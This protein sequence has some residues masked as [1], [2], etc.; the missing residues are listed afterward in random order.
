MY[1]KCGSI[2]RL[3]FVVGIVLA[4]VAQSADPSLVAWYRFDGDASDS[5]G[6]GLHGSEVGDPTYVEGVFGQALDL[7]G[8]GDYID[9]GNPPEFDIREVITFMYWIHVRSFDADWNTVIAKGDNSWRSSRAG[10]NNY[11]E[12]AVS[13]TSGNYLYSTTPVDDGQWHHIAAVYDGATFSIYV[14]GEPDGSEASTGQIASSTYSV[15][16][17]E[18]SQATGRHW[19]GLIDDLMIFNSVLT[20]EEIR[21]IMQSSAG[22]YPFSS[23]PSP[24]DGAL[25][26]QTWVTMSWRA[27]DLA[28]SHDVYFSDNFDDVNSGA[29]AAFHGNKAVT[30]TTLIAGFAGFP[31]PEGLVPGT[32]Y[33]WRVDEVNDSEPNSPWIGNVW[34]FWVPP[35]QAYEPVPAD[36]TTFVP[37]DV[38]LEWTPGFNAKLHYVYFGDDPDVVANATGGSAVSTTSFD[39]G[40]LEFNKTY[41]WRVDEFDPP[42]THRGE[43]WSFATTLPGLGTAV[44]GRWENLT[45]TDLNTLKASPKYP[46]EP[47]VTETVDSFLWD[48]ADL[49]DYGARIEAWVYAPATGDYTFWLNTDDQGEL[50]LSTN[51]DP[52]NARLIAQESSWAPFG[53]WGTGEEQS[54]P[55]PLVGGEKYYI[56]AIWKEGGGGDHCQVGWQGPG[57]PERTVIPG[58]NLSPFEPVKAYGANPANMAADVKQTPTLKWK[59]GIH[60]ES[61]EV[62]FGSDEAAV[63]N[64]TKAS[65]E[66][67][68]SKALG[69]ESFETGKLPWDSSFYWRIDEVADGNP[70]SPWVGDVWSFTTADFVI[71][72]NFEDYTDNDAEGEAVWQTWLDGFGVD[73][74]GSQ[75]GNAVPP[76][77]E[78]NTVQQGRQSVELYYNNVGGVTNSEVERPLEDVRDWTEGGVEEF[79]LWFHGQPASDGSFVE[80]PVGTFTMTG[81]GADITGN[82][83]EFHYAYEMLTGAGSIVARVD[84]VEETHAW[85]KAGVMIRNTLDAGS[86]HAMAFVTPGNGVVFEY[87]PDTDGANV[88]AAGQETGITAPH[89]VKIERDIGGNFTA[90]HS[91]DGSAWQPLGAP[92]N[93]QMGGT[94]F[95]GL[96]LT[97]HDAAATTE[98]V[99]SNVT[100]TGNVTG[101]W[102]NQDV[103]IASN[104]AEP[105]YVGVA[106]ATGAPAIVPHP[107]P[108]AAQIEQWTEWRFPLQDFADKGINL[109]DVRT[110]FIGLGSKGGA[111]SGGSG[112]I[113]LDNIT[114][115]KP[116]SGPQQ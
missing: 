80:G 8:D 115:R 40:P 22:A 72:D 111:A 87:R 92:Q 82:S 85:A 110:L 104:A 95:I 103:G 3:V 15:Y 105:L 108:L 81:S 97:S 31:Y 88:G 76:Y 12:A 6:N 23:S 38:T 94:V 109:S 44:M 96:A 56:M 46:A 65:P 63:A 26:Q 32:T 64:A 14:D 57:I 43:V 35:R 59:P 2:V 66:Y 61:H 39:P 116:E 68:G 21:R 60:A 62:Y 69:E 25:V 100:V 78:L 47:D 4:G 7:D 114:L 16:I 50:W 52:S 51:D 84:S 93:I 79:S 54:D 33:Y 73:T 55:I 30:D 53:S 91:A 107:D 67:K 29:E 1:R 49:S 90:S 86:Q 24:A 102:T 101:Q 13:G 98:A 83:D 41:Y 18:N 20:Q 11:M 58:S 113:F 37:A 45:G 89:W 5:S 75:M 36:G 9:C 42:S 28:A 48:G 77:M 34:S 17:G 74:N 70:D 10:T 112:S 27:G 106:N 71:I 19:N 99:F